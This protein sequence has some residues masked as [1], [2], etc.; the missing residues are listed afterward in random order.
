MSIMSNIFTHN[1]LPFKCKLS[2]KDYW[3]FHLHIGREYG[4]VLSGLQTEC[5]SAFIDTGIDECITRRGLLSVYEWED[6]KAKA[7]TLENIG[8]T[9]VDNGRI[10]FNKDTV[11][12]EEFLE[13][14]TKSKLELKE[15]EKK[16]LLVPVKS[17]L[18]KHSYGYEFV[19][20][21][22]G[23]RLKL[24]GGFFQNFTRVG[25]GCEYSILP[26]EIGDGLSL[27]F[28]LK[29]KDF[30]DYDEST[31]LNGAHPENK[32]I[33]F[34]WG[35]RA[36]NKWVRYYGD[37]CNEGKEPDETTLETS[38]GI[39]LDK[40]T[41][42]PVVSDNKFLTYTR[43]C[44]GHTVLDD[45]E[46]ESDPVVT[47]DAENTVLPD[48]PFLIYSRACG[49]TTVLNDDEYM[50]EHAERYDIYSDLWRNALAFQ[51]TDDGKVGYK[52]LVKD[53]DAEEPECAYKVES[54]FSKPGN[55]PY[56]EWVNIHV[57][58]LPCGSDN[59]RLMF[60]VDGRL[61]LYSRELPKLK[62]RELADSSDKQ[63]GVPFNI[64]LG[65]GTQGL[66]E[67]VYED[68]RTYDEFPVHPLEK[69]FGGSFIGYIKSFKF[70]S[71]S[72]NY[73]QLNQNVE[74]HETVCNDDKI[75]CGA[76]VFNG[77]PS[78]NPMTKQ[79]EYVKLLNE[80][81]Q[82]TR[83]FTIRLLPDISK[84]FLRLV[85]A[86]PQDANLSLVSAVDGMTGLPEEHFTGTDI[87]RLFSRTAME[88]PG[89]DTQY[90]VWYYTYATRPKYNNAITFEID[91]NG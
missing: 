7:M 59:M 75:Y 76:I 8:I 6:A 25:D 31:T 26:S 9:G 89:S 83:K 22:C 74:R 63:E 48:N 69:E 19:N 55:V 38:D 80:Y 33:F 15:D 67:T 66:S 46:G 68:W 28:E 36:E 37:L 16:L 72:L 4:T 49:G 44:G 34:Y 35:T 73:E 27:E 54:E 41:S 91:K 11:T 32:G 81:A 90:D 30:D 47:V 3:D 50:K 23:R 51:V 5:L 70:Y 17:C 10:W 57:R 29:R 24:Y 62:L 85:L 21:N 60:Y 13:V 65:G 61:V 14:F 18:D 84:K 12:D 1:R 52:Y 77:K 53:C 64:S 43:T 39:P 20:D 86:I 88:L 45:K 2:Y 82:D 79:G 40:P 42:N 78:D 58:I 56:G 71:C 87:T